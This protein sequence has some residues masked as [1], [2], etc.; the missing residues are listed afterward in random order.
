MRGRFATPVAGPEAAVAPLAVAAL[1]DPMVT[2]LLDGPDPLAEPA[3]DGVRA[4]FG[5]G[6]AAVIRRP[7]G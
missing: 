2:L 5:C 6:A 7:P 1:G 3:G 4:G